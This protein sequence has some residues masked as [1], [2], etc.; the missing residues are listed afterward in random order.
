MLLGRRS[1]AE[2]YLVVDRVDR[3]I[4]SAFPRPLKDTPDD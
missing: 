2:C 4:T 1:D 3:R